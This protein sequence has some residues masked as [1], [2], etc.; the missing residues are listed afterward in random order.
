MAGQ[1]R[2]RGGKGEYGNNTPDN[3]S[4]WIESPQ[5]IVPGN[6]MP[7]IGIPHQDARDITATFI[8]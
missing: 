7:T 2:H 4:L 1:P 6:A 3:M 5:K 8:P